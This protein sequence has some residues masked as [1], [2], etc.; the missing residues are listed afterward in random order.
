[1]HFD[2]IDIDLLDVISGGA[3][4]D[5]C[6]Q[7]MVAHLTGKTPSPEGVKAC[8]DQGIHFGYSSAKDLPS[9]GQKQKQK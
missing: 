2:T 7:A 6:S 9:A 1:M 3:G 4:D 5:S 8:A